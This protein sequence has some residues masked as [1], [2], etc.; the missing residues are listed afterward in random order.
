MV[1][2]NMYDELQKIKDHNSPKILDQKV[3][4]MTKNN[5]LIY[6]TIRDVL[7]DHIFQCLGDHCKQEKSEKEEEKEG[8]DIPYVDHIPADL[9]DLYTKKFEAAHLGTEAWFDLIDTRNKVDVLRHNLILLADD[10]KKIIDEKREN[11]KHAVSVNPDVKCTCK[12]CTAWL[13]QNPI[14]EYLSKEEKNEIMKEA[15]EEA[16]LQREHMEEEYGDEHNR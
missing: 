12:A 2:C 1:D 11:K 14:D 13:K 9:R 5:G 16:K 10:V 8:M 3:Y 7:A 4:L 15:N 6:Q